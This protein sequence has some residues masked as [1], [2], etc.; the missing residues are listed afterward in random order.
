[1]NKKCYLTYLN[2]SGMKTLIMSVILSALIMSCEKEKE[3]KNLCPVIAKEIVPAAVRDSFN[4]KY[5]HAIIENWFYKDNAL[6]CVS[7]T[8][9]S[10]SSLSTFNQSGGF[11]KEV[12]DV[13][14]EGNDEQDDDAGCKCEV[15]DHD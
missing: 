11:I 2:N 8:I 10:R 15:A 4:V 14:Q 13:Q 12:S 3:H 5:P 7:F 1:M 9:D 6:Y